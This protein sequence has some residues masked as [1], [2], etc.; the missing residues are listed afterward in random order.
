MA[1]ISINNR[2]L[3][4]IKGDNLADVLNNMIDD[5]LS[6]D[7]ENIDTVFVDEC[8]N[9][10]LEFE[11][12]NNNLSVLI[13]L[14]S[15]NEFLKKLTRDK[16]SSFKNLN[17]FARSAI[18]AA[19]IAG[20]TFSVNAMVQSITGTDIISAIAEKISQAAS[21]ASDGDNT[22]SFDGVRADISVE[23]TTAAL[24]TETAT[25]KSEPENAEKSESAYASAVAGQETDNA[26][27]DETQ[28]VQTAQTAQAESLE[29]TEEESTSVTVENTASA[30]PVITEKSMQNKVFTEITA[31]I[32]QMKTDYIYG[33]KISFDGLKL[34]ANYSDCSR[35]PVK[36]TDCYYSKIYNTNETADYTLT[37]IYKTCTLKIKITVRP[38]EDTR[39]S[40]ICSNSD[41]DYLL[42]DS[43]AYIT[44]YKGSSTS[45]VLDYVDGNRVIA[46]GAGIFE[47]NGVEEISA[48]YVTKIFENAFKDCTSLVKCDMPNTVYIGE[49]A[50][51]GCEK[52]KEISYSD[53]IS[54]FGASAFG[55]TALQSA[56]IPQ[57]ITEIPDYLFTDCSELTQVTF[58]GSVTQI[59]KWSFADC[60]ALEKVI[61]CEDIISVGDYAFYNDDTVDFDVFP[62]GIET[63]GD[64]AFY[65]CQSLSIG[66]L[67]QKITALGKS[68]FAYCSGLTELT[69][70]QGI[71]VIPY[72]AF[73]GTGAKTVAIPEGVEVIE[74]YALRATKATAISLPNSL[75]RIGAYGIYS[76]LLRKI[77]VNR[78]IEEIADNAVYPGRSVTLYVYDGSVGLKYAAEKSI[79]YEIIG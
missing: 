75:K 66:S 12:D 79:G 40:E 26:P 71:T 25:H 70:P 31:D 58:K 1:Q 13:P 52:L 18:I 44:A 78:D 50:F 54:C 67:P 7:V 3:C 16:H 24:P 48:D 30:K 46:I 23:T 35:E 37:I 76:P 69:I 2:V 65:L 38:D 36:L 11:N 19:I 45:L 43:G 49:S 57:S 73:R 32:S 33:E 20:S 63:V 8:V 60:T 55:K 10:L 77:Y 47:N 29:I 51:E 21:D 56:V 64:C 53:N 72:E 9:A 27:P 59:G 22:D 15:S 6:K 42:T 5:E 14:V 34:Y 68:S 61:G 4:N 28:T 41:F 62:K 74:D 39:G 17:I